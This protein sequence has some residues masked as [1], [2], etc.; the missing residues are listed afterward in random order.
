MIKI[1]VSTLEDSTVN[2][3]SVSIIFDIRTVQLFPKNFKIL[4]ELRTER[5]L[6]LVV[7]NMKKKRIEIFSNP[8][9]WYNKTSSNPC[10]E[11]DDENIFSSL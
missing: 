1:F 8:L 5:C 7:K 9:E 4:L 10:S 2:F 6:I 3:L 11:E